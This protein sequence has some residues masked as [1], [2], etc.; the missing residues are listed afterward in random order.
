MHIE[1]IKRWQW[2][3]LGLILGLALG[4]SRRWAA[5][6]LPSY[7][8]GINDQRL[9]ET[10]VLRSIGASPL[11]KDIRVSRQSLDDGS[12][13]SESLY[14]VSGK[15]VAENAK[16]GEHYKPMWFAAHVPYQPAIDL[17][18]LAGP[19]NAN[20]AARWQ[21]IPQPT[22]IDWLQLAHE[23]AGI[24][25]TN[26]WWDTYPLRTFTLAGF[27]VIGILFPTIINLYYFQSLTRP[28]SEKGVSLLGVHSPQSA[29]AA[30]TDSQASEAQL[31]HLRELEQELEATLSG[32]SSAPAGPE[33][34]SPV[35]ALAA[36]AAAST[37]E[38]PHDDRHFRAKPEDFY[39]TEDRAHPPH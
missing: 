2:M 8:E 37:S 31:T 36:D 39:P 38:Q 29:T 19:N 14:V 30:A 34:A 12:G 4:Y 35:R 28:R 6:D 25:Y 1:S 7:G 11:F 17:T 16:A 24:S 13:N 23:S 27:L 20:A 5:T 32:E 3:I 26:A 10:R 15:S 22:V 9:F 21:S 33:T 18:Q